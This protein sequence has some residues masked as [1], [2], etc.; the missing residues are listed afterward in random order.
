MTNVLLEDIVSGIAS[1]AARTPNSVASH[2]LSAVAFSIQEAA[3][4]NGM[5]LSKQYFCK[6]PPKPRRWYAPWRN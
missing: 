2:A 4:K 6:A 1:A 3:E 5:P